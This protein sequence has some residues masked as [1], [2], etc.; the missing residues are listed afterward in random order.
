MSRSQWGFTTNVAPK[1]KS[2]HIKKL[3]T[4][5]KEYKEATKQTKK[6]HGLKTKP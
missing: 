3:E 6:A 1:Q 2:S 4:K 5:S